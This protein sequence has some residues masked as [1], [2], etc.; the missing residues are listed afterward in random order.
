[1]SIYTAMRAGVSGLNANAAAMAVISDNIANVNTTSYKRGQADF[2]QLVNLQGISGGY[3]AGGVTA[4]TRRLVDQQGSLERTRSST[5]LGISGA[6]FFIVTDEPSNRAG[7]SG[8]LFT[9][10]GSFSL[11]SKGQMVNS[12]GLFLLGAPITDRQSQNIAPS[13]L[14]ALE[15]IDLSQVGAQAEA[16]SNVSISANL[17]A[18]TQAAPAYAAGDLTNQVTPPHLERAVEV[19]DSLGTV[20]TL[21]L[22][23]LKV[24]TPLNRWAVEVYHNNPTT[25]L[26]EQLA[27][28][29]L[30]FGPDGAPIVDDPAFPP[31]DTVSINW[32]DIAPPDPATVGTG[33]ADQDVAFDLVGGMTQYAVNSG[34]NSATADGS[35]PGDLIGVN[36]SREGVLTAQFS[37]GRID[38]LYIIPVATFLNPN[39]LALANRGAF[40][41]TIDS[42]LL[43]INTAG[44]SG[45]GVIQSNSL[46]ASNVDL[47]TEF[48]TMITT[49]R[50]YSASSRV[51]TTADEMLEELIRIKR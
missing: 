11:D 7:A 33:A 4:G 27:A 34:L 5:D 2:A 50:A 31:V 16:T 42:G 6:G 36:I 14:A 22:A 10:S 9:R 43:T 20:R 51:I 49:Q 32:T 13:T 26:R 24:S 46:E 15:P 1:M 30:R 17:D 44:A 28:G 25:G 35:P 29:Y 3:S 38:P 45:A 21:N 23:F 8:G 37:N 39:G 19:Y 18:R 48:T 41:Q 40:G 47:G 12:Q